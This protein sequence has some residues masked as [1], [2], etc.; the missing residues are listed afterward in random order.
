MAKSIFD[1]YEKTV[2]EKFSFG[3]Q[4]SRLSPERQ[5]IYCRIIGIVCLFAGIVGAALFIRSF[6]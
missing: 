3:K 1:E 4:W 2:K 5:H 6:S